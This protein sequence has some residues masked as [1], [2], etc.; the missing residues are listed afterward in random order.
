MDNRLLAQTI[1]CFAVAHGLQYADESRIHA[2][3]PL[4]VPV[5]QDTY[6]YLLVDVM[7]DEDG[8]WVIIEINGSN[9]AGSIADRGDIPRVRHLVSSW[10]NNGLDGDVFIVAYQDGT[11]C[12]PEIFA[13]VAAIAGNLADEDIEVTVTSACG[14]RRAAGP[15]LVVDTTENIADQLALGSDGRLILSGRLVRGMS[16]ANVLPAMQ[17]RA[18]IRRD[19]DVDLRVLHEG[20]IFHPIIADKCSQQRLAE[21]TGFRALRFTSIPDEAVTA[22]ALVAFARDRDLMAK[23]NGGSGGAGV[24]TVR[25]GIT[26]DA[27][28]EATAAALAQ[29]TAKYGS[30][31]TAF[32]MGAFEFVR[33]RHVVGDDG[34]RYQWDLRL[35]VMISPGE[36]EMTPL[37]VRV[38]PAPFDESLSR[39]ATIANLTDTTDGEERVISAAVL[40]AALRQAVDWTE[41]S[42]YVAELVAVGVAA[43]AEPART[44]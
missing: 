38:C 34:R 44:T 33:A 25:R 5:E 13:R 3:P 22:D 41:L 12:Q 36:V 4:K 37:S 35:Q 40:P 2:A 29:V 9:A 26:R 15:V 21:G 30:T 43:H 14:V 17:R 18:T 20:P 28:I 23:I 7:L 10:L 11:P 27:A 42:E 32:P 19:E 6:S 31:A 1:A 39:E 8:R 16:N 24:F